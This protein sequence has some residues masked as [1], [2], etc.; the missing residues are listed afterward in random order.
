MRQSV[1][2]RVNPNEASDTRKAM[3]RM[4]HI[5]ESI[6]DLLVRQG[7]ANAK[8]V[9]AGKVRGIGAGLREGAD[10]PATARPEGGRREPMGMGKKA[11]AE[12]PAVNREVGNRHRSDSGHMGNSVFRGFV[13]HTNHNVSTMPTRQGAIRRTPSLVCIE[14]GKR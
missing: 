8:P 3:I 9:G 14:G 10:R 4:S 13:V 2:V 12:A 11:G 1:L 6:R 5:S 7:I